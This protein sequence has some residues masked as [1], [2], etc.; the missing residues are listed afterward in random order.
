MRAGRVLAA[1]DGRDSVYPDDVRQVLKP[2]MAHRLI[3]SPEAV[4][5]GETVDAV[6]DRVVGKVRPPMLSAT[7]STRVA[8]TA[9]LGATEAGEAREAGARA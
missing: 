6:L 4:L 5:R 3:L 2:V 9:P 8:S 7:A 1:S